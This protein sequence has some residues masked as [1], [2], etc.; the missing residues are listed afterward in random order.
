M[1]PR[2]TANAVREK[3]VALFEQWKHTRNADALVQDL[4]AILGVESASVPKETHEQVLDF[5]FL[6]GDEVVRFQEQGYNGG[7]YC[8]G[9]DGEVSGVGEEAVIIPLK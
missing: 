8:G 7:G 5:I 2:R 4:L 1:I 9:V 6:F 3:V